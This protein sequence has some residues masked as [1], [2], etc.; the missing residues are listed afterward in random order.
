M[1]PYGFRPGFT[2]EKEIRERPYCVRPRSSS[3]GIV[4]DFRAPRHA[5]RHRARLDTAELVVEGCTPICH[6]EYCSGWTAGDWD[7]ACPWCDR[8]VM[9]PCCPSY[10][11]PF[12]LAPMVV[13][14]G[15]V[16]KRRA[17]A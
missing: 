15:D 13:T 17:A 6:C 4:R 3:A 9:G 2:L 11:K 16:R 14:I 5:A 8:V 1:R 7:D 10:G 12:V